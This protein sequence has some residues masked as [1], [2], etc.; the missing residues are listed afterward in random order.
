MSY[1]KL[2]TTSD[3]DF[4]PLSPSPPLSFPSSSRPFVLSPLLGIFS[5]DDQINV[6]HGVFVRMGS[7]VASPFNRNSS[8]ASRGEGR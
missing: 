5:Q 1:F 7:V 8:C 4:S 3:L 6:Y 2:A